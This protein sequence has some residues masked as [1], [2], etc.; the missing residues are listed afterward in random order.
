LPLKQRG[1]RAEPA[2]RV[3][4]QQQV[5]DLNRNRVRLVALDS[6]FDGFIEPNASALSSHVF[7]LD[8]F[9]RQNFYEAARFGTVTVYTRP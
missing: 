6:H 1:L 7:L 5:Q 2:L 8:K 9:L 3:R 4:S